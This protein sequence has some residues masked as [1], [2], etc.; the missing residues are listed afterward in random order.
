MTTEAWPRLDSE[1]AEPLVLRPPPHK[2]WDL[3]RMAR[4]FGCA[5]GT[6]RAR[7]KRG[8]IPGPYIR[9]RGRYLWDPDDVAQA[10]AEWRR[11]H[12]NRG[13]QT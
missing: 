13:G 10:L 8:E 12:P 6:I 4:E 9:D 7:V 11:T 2:A 3:T 1:Y 5:G